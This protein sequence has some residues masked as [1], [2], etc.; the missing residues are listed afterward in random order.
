MAGACINHAGEPHKPQQ[1][2]VTDRI[3][4]SETGGDRR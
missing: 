4:D 2:R 1:L 3:G